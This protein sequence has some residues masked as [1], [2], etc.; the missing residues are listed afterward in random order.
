VAFLAAKT[1]SSSSKM[2]LETKI[3]TLKDYI[4]IYRLSDFN[5]AS[6]S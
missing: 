6:I 3:I 5:L 2:D 1:A 4:F